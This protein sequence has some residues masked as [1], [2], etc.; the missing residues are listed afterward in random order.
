MGKSLDQLIGYKN[1]TGLITSPLGGVP[2]VWPSELLGMTQDIVGDTA[3]WMRVKNSRQNPPLTNYG[4]ASKE[5]NQEDLIKSAAKCIHSATHISHKM[6]V[7]TALRN[8]EDMGAQARGRQVVDMQT[9]EFRR[10][11]DNLRVSALNSVF[12]H[13][14]LYVDGAGNILPTSAGQVQTIDFQQSANNRDQ[15]NGVI[16]ASWATAGTDILGQLLTLQRTAVQTTGLPLTRAYFGHL[17][18][19]SLTGNTTVKE[20]MKSNRILTEQLMSSVIPADFGIVGMKWYPLHMAFMN[21]AAGAVQNWFPGDYVV[22]MPEPSRD[23]WVT[24]QGSYEVPTRI[25][26]STT[27]EEA[28]ASLATVHGKFSYVSLE[29]NPPRFN[30]YAGDTFLP[31]PRNP[32]AFYIADTQ[33]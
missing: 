7:L 32:D 10:K 21:D 3:E 28:L 18:P 5:I 17:V 20:L 16:A 26:L 1:L 8:F 4:S 19:A 33:F 15:L 27:V 11:Y 2:M 25:G 30:H 31:I 24:Q 22:F 14:K 6:D 13:A 9:A 12:R 29:H 23:W